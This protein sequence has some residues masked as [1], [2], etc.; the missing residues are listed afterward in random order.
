MEVAVPAPSPRG[1]PP[2]PSPRTTDRVHV[3]TRRR[4][5]GAAAKENRRQQ[6]HAKASPD[7]ADTPSKRMTRAA[8][9]AEC[10]E[11]STGNETQPLTSCGGAA[12]AAKDAIVAPASATRPSRR[13][14][15]ASPTRRVP[16]NWQSQPSDPNAV[17]LS[18]DSADASSANA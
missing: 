18:K 4:G 11:N 15:A 2:T 10:K 5:G 1:G 9:A 13:R 6:Q 17:P 8:A 14:T 3:T 7:P 12:T 16:R